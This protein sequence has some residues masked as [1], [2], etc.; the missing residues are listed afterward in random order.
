M[1]P[2]DP[3][4]PRRSGLDSPSLL[5]NQKQHSASLLYG[6][7]EVGAYGGKPSSTTA[8]VEENDIADTSASS[9]DRA[10]LRQLVEGDI[11]AEV[12]LTSSGTTTSEQKKLPSLV[13]R[14][15][16]VA[17]RLSY[18][19]RRR[20]QF[21]CDSSIQI[22]EFEQ[23]ATNSC[24]RTSNMSLN[25]CSK[26]NS[27]L[28]SGSGFSVS[29]AAGA[30]G[31]NAN[32]PQKNQGYPVEHAKYVL[33]PPNQKNLRTSQQQP[34]SSKILHQ[35]HGGQGNNHSAYGDQ[36]Q[37]LCDPSCRSA[38][39]ESKGHG[40]QPR[41]ASSSKSSYTPPTGS[42]FWEN[43]SFAVPIPGSKTK[44]KFLLNNCYGELIPGQLT[45]LV[46]P[47]GAGKSTLLNILAA[48]QGWTGKTGRICFVESAGK[49]T[50][51]AGPPAGAE[52]INKRTNIKEMDFNDLR[53]TVAYVMQEDHL[54]PTQTVKETLM[55]AARLKLTKK[56]K[57]EHN[58]K[59]LTPSSSGTKSRRKICKNLL[60]TEA[61]IEQ[62]V[63]ETL[64]DL[65]LQAVKDV[66]IGSALKK[67][68]SGGQK[69][70]V[71]TAIELLGRPKLLFLDEPTSGLDSFS[72]L[73]LITKLREIAQRDKAIICCTIHQP[74]SE[75][76]DNFD[77]VLCL[78]AG[79]VLLEGY[80]G[81]R[82]AALLRDNAYTATSKFNFQSTELQLSPTA[83]TSPLVTAF[84]SSPNELN[85][86]TAALGGLEEEEQQITDGTNIKAVA[87]SIEGMPLGREQEEAST[88][89]QDRDGGNNNVEMKIFSST[90]E[91]EEASRDVEANDHVEMK[92]QQE[93]HPSNLLHELELSR[94][95]F[96]KNMNAVRLQT[97][98]GFLELIVGQPIPEGY[99][100]CD[101]LLYL[102]QSFSNEEFLFVR[103]NHKALF[104]GLRGKK[105][106]IEQS[107]ED[108][109][110][111]S[112]RD[113]LEE[114]VEV[115]QLQPGGREQH[116]NADERTPDLLHPLITNL[117]FVQNDEHD[118]PRPVRVSAKVNNR[119]SGGSC[120]RRKT[121]RSSTEDKN[122]GGGK[123]SDGAP[124]SDYTDDSSD[125]SEGNESSVWSDST[126][127]SS[128]DETN[129]AEN[130]LCQDSS[131]TQ[132][133]A[134]EKKALLQAVAVEGFDAQLRP[135]SSE[136][137]STR[138]ST[139]N[140]ESNEPKAVQGKKLLE[141]TSAR[142]TASVVRAKNT[143]GKL[144][145][146]KSPITRTSEF[147]L[148]LHREWSHR[149]RDVKAMV[150][151][152]LIPSISVI[153]YSLAYANVARE[154]TFGIMR[155]YAD[156]NNPN[157]DYYVHGEG[158]FR[159]KIR[160]LHGP[161]GQVHL[162]VLMSA[163]QALLM[164]I[165]VE[166][167]IFNREFHSQLYSVTPY[168]MSKIFVESILILLQS[169]WL[170]FLPYVFWGL[171]AN[172]LLLWATMAFM[173]F[174]GMAT[175]LMLAT[176]NVNAPERALLW[177]PVFLT[178]I[179][180]CFSGSYRPLE[181]MPA[182][183]SWM[184]WITPSG[185]LIK[186][187]S[188]VEFAAISNSMAK[189]VESSSSET[190]SD[191]LPSNAPYTMAEIQDMYTGAL[192]RYW[193]GMEVTDDL[194]FVIFN[195]VFCFV[196]LLAF[197]VSSV[198]FLKVNSRTL[199]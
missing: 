31:G 102:A 67:G 181:D 163:A 129:R 68:L 127:F 175:G 52:I 71:S 147:N 151:K 32:Q 161:L 173:G 82:A 54:L 9:I 98:S 170:L 194:N 17:S 85:R 112:S 3:S 130:K 95:Q 57:Q 152:M 74:S 187:I 62:R 165:A 123:S 63:E 146:G 164:G 166:R 27:G 104:L 30:S 158:E 44:K 97:V 114:S 167:P 8:L 66:A 171:C 185:Y 36:Q 107:L 120:R 144:S 65:D 1:K 72:S 69:K 138:S 79:E 41:T 169:A 81:K 195:W 198:L 6:D 176:M 113:L 18:A 190:R 105:H 24:S 90:A 70:R 189:L 92:L 75:L 103:E 88:V 12:V 122:G 142:S 4:F 186:L 153:I 53:S 174:C 16:D 168:V 78:R 178:A 154:L 38:R 80:S 191:F 141:N 140:D 128:D 116:K 43:L 162:V 193:A 119:G 84:A 136:V 48:R 183:L 37:E 108:E 61:E 23:A 110:R 155:T 131:S 42:L 118:D 132:D 13:Q 19:A 137:V 197:L 196:L 60:L 76:F 150:S 50:N 55:F 145:T 101:W 25:R 125:E 39:H 159:A 20:T 172:F 149:T 124:S 29:L 47:S 156:P 160:E 86:K 179:P 15:S 49:T 10:T 89:E 7:A 33:N 11:F 35:Q 109:L 117:I 87:F 157:S 143:K 177:G 64:T 22:A 40:L 91:D 121:R 139:K 134:E 56:Q 111:R 83:C 180:S 59:M 192:R 135:G 188:Y 14:H 106:E 100:T 96:F 46:G 77:R 93:H 26:L 148:L 73:R 199:Y 21:S 184:Q 182:Y 28:L 2:H 115:Q 45:A 99:G 126:S 34:K 51:A 133:I 5:K 58:Q 94:E